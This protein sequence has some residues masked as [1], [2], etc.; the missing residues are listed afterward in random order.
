VAGMS[1]IFSINCFYALFTVLSKVVVNDFFTFAKLFALVA[2]LIALVALAAP[3]PALDALEPP[4]DTAKSAKSATPKTTSKVID[5]IEEE[6]LSLSS[7]HAPIPQ[8]SI[9]M[10]SQSL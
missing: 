7:E 3:V 4:K 1:F 10:F 8:F 9:P 6:H 2:L 5:T